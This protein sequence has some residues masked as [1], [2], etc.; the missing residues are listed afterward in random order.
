MANVIDL[1]SKPKLF[2]FTDF[3]TRSLNVLE[4]MESIFG[5]MPINPVS[6]EDSL[7]NA[8]WPRVDIISDVNFTA[9]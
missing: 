6:I 9:N 5:P 8:N 2:Y 7:I 1:D 3:E 4:L